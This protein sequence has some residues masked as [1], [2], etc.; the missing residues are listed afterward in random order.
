MEIFLLC[1]TEKWPSVS[2]C[3]SSFKSISFSTSLCLPHCHA[4]TMC[5]F[6]PIFTEYP[7]K[8][9]LSF[10]TRYLN[11]IIF[12]CKNSWVNVNS[13][14]SSRIQK[15]CLL[16]LS[17]SFSSQIHTLSPCWVHSQ[18]SLHIPLIFPL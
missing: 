2:K 6:L 16:P 15:R 12:Y 10:L 11:A 1:L 9:L 5:I 17:T 8:V 14:S 18:T 7:R 3:Y 4:H 13:P